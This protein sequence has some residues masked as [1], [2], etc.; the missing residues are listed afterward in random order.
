[1]YNRKNPK[2]QFSFTRSFTVKYIGQMKMSSGFY[3]EGKLYFV[4]VDAFR[5][6]HGHT[7][8]K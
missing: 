4:N 7:S 8:N 5:E 3:W 2:T 1:M 6:Y